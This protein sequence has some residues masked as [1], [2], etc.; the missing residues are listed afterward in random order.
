MDEQKLEKELEEFTKNSEIYN[1]ILK[2]NIDYAKA[3]SLSEKAAKEAAY[4]NIKA[5]DD[6]SKM[7]KRTSKQIEGSLD[8]LAES[9]KKQ[10]ATVEDVEEQL[11]RLRGEINRTAD[12]SAKEALIN[13]KA[14]LEEMVL[15]K[16]VGDNLKETM[17]A[18][19]VGAG[20][21]VASGFKEAAKTAMASGD[22]IQTAGGLMKAG[23]DIANSSVQM[24]AS[25]MKDIGGQMAQMGGKAKAVGVSLSFLGSVTGMVA[26]GLSEL[27]KAGI[28]MM[29]KAVTKSIE[30]FRT[31]S[32]SGALFSDGVMGMRRAATAAGMSLDDFSKVASSNKEAFASLGLGVSGG[33]Q[34]MSKA[35][36]AGGITMRKQLFALGY[37]MEDQ[38]NMMAGVMSTMA[39]P[40]GRLKASDAQVAAATKQYAQNLSLLS[41]LTGEDIKAKEAAIKKENETLAFQQKLDGMSEEERLNIQESMKGMS[42]IQ[43]KALRERMLYGTA[44]SADVNIYEAQNSA[45]KAQHD[46]LF[47]LQKN[48]ELTLDSTIKTQSEYGPSVHKAN[49]AMKESALASLTVGGDLA[50]ANKG[51]LETSQLVQKLQ[52]KS[53]DEQRKILA[54]QQKNA[55]KDP[56]VTVQ[57]QQREFGIEMDKLTNTHMKQFGDALGETMKI[58]KGAMTEFSEYVTK[59]AKNPG[60]TATILG[61]ITAL[62]TAMPVISM[63]LTAIL[64]KKGGGD[65]GGIDTP[66]SKGKPKGPDSKPKG[67]IGRAFDAVKSVGSRALGFLPGMG[68]TAAEAATVAAPAAASTAAGATGVLG[69]TLGVAAKGLKFLGPAGAVA[70]LGYGGYQGY[71]NAGANFDLEPGKEATAGQKLSST[72]AGALS[73]LTFGL[74]NEKSAAQGIHGASSAVGGFLSKSASGIGNLVSGG[75][76]LIGSGAS[77]LASKVG[78]GSGYTPAGGMDPKQFLEAQKATNDKITTSMKDVGETIKTNNKTS[79]DIADLMRTQLTKQDELIAILKESLDIN[80]RLLTQAQG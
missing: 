29:I 64:N 46:K 34:K 77:A 50:A 33:I 7:Y 71:Q 63:L 55:D 66:D 48:H 18:Q 80:Q 43:R 21:A 59:A 35:M 10:E 76:N 2:E 79:T 15:R 24:G 68:A 70:G 9:Y 3:N 57:E 39:G 60:W 62:S 69:K 53:V 17:M 41:A 23:I 44:V 40:A 11:Q 6:A 54:D 56:M 73:S 25:S 32:Q 45:A 75:A 30:T 1:H 19:V 4:R 31:M 8:I 47:T 22:G 5:I 28:D 20:V 51:A 61:A 36:E 74:L 58:A 42:E 49:M 12:Q 37:S 16:K 78:L 13:K 26:G 38:G 14:S 67:R 72:A 52:G 27:A 65:G